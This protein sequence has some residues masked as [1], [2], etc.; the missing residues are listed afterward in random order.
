[1][2]Y[3]AKNE[4]THQ[5]P[6]RPPPAHASPKEPHTMMAAAEIPPVLHHRIL[7]IMIDVAEMFMIRERRAAETQKQKEASENR[8]DCVLKP[9]LFSMKVIKFKL[10]L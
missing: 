3:G 6:A 10:L 4:A 9:S 5:Y 2:Q 8:D 7:M 1:M